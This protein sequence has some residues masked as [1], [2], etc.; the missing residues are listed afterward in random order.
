MVICKICLDL[1]ILL[2]PLYEVQSLRGHL[3]LKCSYEMIYSYSA[4]KQTNNDGKATT[5]E[6]NGILKEIRTARAPFV[7]KTKIFDICYKVALILITCICVLFIIWLGSVSYFYVALAIISYFFLLIYSL[8][9][10]GKV[11]SRYDKESRDTC[12]TIIDRHNQIFAEKGLRWVL[13]HLDYPR[14]VELWKEYCGLGPGQMQ[15]PGE[16]LNF[17]PGTPGSE[18]VYPLGLRNQANQ[19]GGISIQHEN[20]Y[21]GAQINN[22][23]IPPNQI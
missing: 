9:W 10:K 19:T 3:M 5:E 13:P 12:Q 6:I 15:L 14:W 20:P 18:N 4:N 22:G 11:V 7:T 17:P 8:V 2:H 23:C 21:S 16:Y 1:I